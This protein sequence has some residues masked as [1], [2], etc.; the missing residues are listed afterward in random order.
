MQVKLMGL[1]ILPY[2][3][4]FYNLKLRCDKSG[5]EVSVPLRQGKILIVQGVYLPF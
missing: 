3:T 1:V 2:K 4:E 5:Y